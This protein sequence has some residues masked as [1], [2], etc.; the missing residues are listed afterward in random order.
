MYTLTIASAAERLFRKLPREVKARLI[1]E[2]KVLKTEPMKGEPLKGKYRTFRSLHLAFKGTQ[3]R[4]IYQV[5]TEA[6]MVTI[7]LAA[8]RENIYK[9]LEEMMG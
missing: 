1:E 8:P 3:Y 6:Q 9:K 5:F 4:I 7:R 2:A